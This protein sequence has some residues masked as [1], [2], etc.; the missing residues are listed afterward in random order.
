VRL[1]LLVPPTVVSVAEG[2]EVRRA[3][4]LAVRGDR[5][6]VCVRRGVGL[7]HLR[8]VD[9]AALDPGSAGRDEQRLGPD[10]DRS[11]VVGQA[12]RGQARPSG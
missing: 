11:F 7:N 9:A 2:G 3:L 5:R 12:R 4:L 1:Q 6:Y 10:P 8:W